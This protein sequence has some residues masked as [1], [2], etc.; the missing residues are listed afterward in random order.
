MPAAEELEKPRV[1]KG[2]ADYLSVG[3]AE[4]LVLTL[5]RGK[6]NELIRETVLQDPITAPL[7]RGDAVGELTLTLDGQVIE[8]R[9]IVALEP[10]ETGGFFARL[11][12]MILMW[13]AKLF[14]G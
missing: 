1:W 4:D 3:I 8:Q 7:A 13:L 11:W 12:D 9:P 10:L 5:P 6:R 14:G 2:Q